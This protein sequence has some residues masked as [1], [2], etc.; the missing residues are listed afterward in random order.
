MKKTFRRRAPRKRTTRKGTTRKRTYGGRK[1]RKMRG[2][3]NRSADKN[4]FTVTFTKSEIEQIE[5]FKKTNATTNEIYNSMFQEQVEE[6]DLDETSKDELKTNI[7][8]E[9]QKIGVDGNL[10]S[11]SS[12]FHPT[13]SGESSLG[14]QIRWSSLGSHDAGGAGAAELRPNT[15]EI[16]PKLS[17]QYT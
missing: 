16:K 7:I 5:A 8:K 15:V 12:S 1:L 2:G 4:D 9:I 6:I 17:R 3:F 10:S 11:V 14:P 13:A